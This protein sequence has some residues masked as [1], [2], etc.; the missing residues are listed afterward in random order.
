MVTGGC[1]GARGSKATACTTSWEQAG[2]PTRQ[3]PM[4][5]GGPVAPVFARASQP[6]RP[7]RDA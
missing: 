2:L 6:P 3:S 1:L 5:I 4:K 7:G